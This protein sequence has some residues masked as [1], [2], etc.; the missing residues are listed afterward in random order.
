MKRGQKGPKQVVPMAYTSALNNKKSDILTW[1]KQFPTTMCL[2]QKSSGGVRGPIHDSQAALVLIPL[3]CYQAYIEYPRTVDVVEVYKPECVKNRR[4]NLT[5]SL[6]ISVGCPLWYGF[7]QKAAR[8]SWGFG[9][10]GKNSKWCSSNLPT[11]TDEKHSF[12]S[13]EIFISHSER[14]V[15]KKVAWCLIKF[16]P[17]CY[18]AYFNARLI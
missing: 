12:Q 5:E 13:V 3:R 7:L 18:K 15:N 11:G 14:S 2:S 9:D 1:K 8:T 6:F 4:I 16:I 10:R 17:I